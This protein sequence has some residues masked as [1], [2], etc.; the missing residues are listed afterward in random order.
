[1]KNVMTKAHEITKKIIRKGDSYRETFRLALIFVHSQIKKGVKK[2]VE[3]KGTEKQVKWA[4]DIRINL[5][6]IIDIAT[7][8]IEEDCKSR[9]ER[10][11]SK[12]F[13]TVEDMIKRNIERNEEV[14]EMIFNIEDSKFLIENFK[15]VTGKESVNWISFVLQKIAN[16]LS[17]IDVDNKKHWSRLACEMQSLNSQKEYVKYSQMFL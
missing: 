16:E 10:R 8:T 5:S 9:W 3:L 14:K 15:I 7:S 11:P 17:E 4:M 12:K 6:K 2:M 13:T 1:M